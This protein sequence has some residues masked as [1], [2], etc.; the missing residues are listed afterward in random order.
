MSRVQ[1]PASPADFVSPA[2]GREAFHWQQH[3]CLWADRKGPF[4]DALLQKSLKYL[5]SPFLRLV[6]FTEFLSGLV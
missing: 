3:C 2:E 6:T 5:L 4:H 1:L